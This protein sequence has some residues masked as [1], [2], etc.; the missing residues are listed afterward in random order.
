MKKEGGREKERDKNEKE[1]SIRSSSRRH[2]GDEGLGDSYL[3]IEE[4]A[5]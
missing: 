3:R 4:A 5:P 1:V 2:K